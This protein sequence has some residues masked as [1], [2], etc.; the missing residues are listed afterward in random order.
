MRTDLIINAL[1]EK[2]YK[3]ALNKEIKEISE[4]EKLARKLIEIG[5]T[6][7]VT[8]DHLCEV[9]NIEIPKLTDKECKAIA[10]DYPHPFDDI[11]STFGIKE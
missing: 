3:I 9:A 4:N 6:L 11:K 1:Q 10:C 8:I 5:M 7:N 2:G